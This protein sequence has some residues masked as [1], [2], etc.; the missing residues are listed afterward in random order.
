MA[1][2]PIKSPLA[3]LHHLEEVLE[4]LRRMLGRLKRA[5]GIGR[6][7]TAE[8]FH[9]LS[10][11]A[12]AIVDYGRMV[13]GYFGQSMTTVLVETTEL[14]SRFRETPQTIEDALLLLSKNGRASADDRPGC[15]KVRLGCSS[16][17][18]HDVAL[19]SDPDKQRR[20]SAQRSLDPLPL[21]GVAASA[22]RS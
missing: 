12:E 18:S 16:I 22:E 2:A 4:H 14:A 3:I 5:L 6:R 13:E 11:L 19:D 8:E 1:T 15:W 7:L 10:E 17:G 20:H 9:Q 21:A